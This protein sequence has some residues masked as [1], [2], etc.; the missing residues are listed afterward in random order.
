VLR[1]FFGIL[2]HWQVKARTA[3]TMLSP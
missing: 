1:L 3:T 2:D